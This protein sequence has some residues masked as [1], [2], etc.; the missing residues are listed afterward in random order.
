MVAYDR[1]G[2]TYRNTRRPDPR[3]A[4]QVRDAL[5]T[6]GTVVNVGAGTGSY[7][8]GQTV[9]AIEP[10]MVMIAQRPPGSAPCVQAVA[11]A[12]PLRD[13]CVDAAMALL[14]V[15]HWGDLSAGIAELRRVSRHRIVIFTWDQAVIDDFWLLREYLPDAARINNALYVP[16]ERLVELLGG[17]QMHTVPIP[18]DCADGFGAAFWR[19]PEAYL[20]ATVR[21][22]ISMLAYADE[23]ALADGLGRLAADLRSERWQRRHAELLEQQQLD[24]GYRLL[25]SDGG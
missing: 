8:P 21:A 23:G 13:K 25:I 7:E 9:A 10:S 5:A 2:A 19:R 18:H 17:A 6:M 20:D 3:I 22:G 24:A 16:I 12:L 11:E 4:S 14:T 15:H 1:I